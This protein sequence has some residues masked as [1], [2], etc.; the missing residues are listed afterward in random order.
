MVSTIVPHFSPVVSQVSPVVTHDPHAD[1]IAGHARWRAGD[2]LES[3]TTPADRRGWA[4]AEL[5]GQMAY[6]TAME[7]AGHNAVELVW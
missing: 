1:L 7:A 3:C 4:Q 2:R 6:L 5:E